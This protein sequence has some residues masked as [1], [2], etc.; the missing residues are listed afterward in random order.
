MGNNK[1][2]NKIVVKNDDFEKSILDF[3][4]NLDINK[5]QRLGVAV[6]GGSD[7]LSL[8]VA[9]NNLKYDVLAILVNHNLRKN[10]LNEIKQTSK[11][12]EKFGIKYVIKQWDGKY[13]K[14][15]E[16]EAR[17]NRYRL[18][19]ETCKENKIKFL[20]IGHHIDDQMETFLLNL[21]RGSGLDGLCAM[22]KIMNANDINI[23][24]PMLNLTKQDCRNYLKNIN[25]DWCE[26]ESN[27][28][29]KYKRN[30]IR[31]LLNQFEDKEILTKRI[32][33]SVD[34]LQEVREFIDDYIETIFNDKNIIFFNDK[35]NQFEINKNE[36]LKLKKYIQKSIIVKCVAVISKIEYKVSLYKTENILN[37]I[38]SNKPFKR[39]IEKCFV[40]SE[41]R[42]ISRNKIIIAYLDNTKNKQ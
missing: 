2:N 33:R 30:K 6:S 13:K 14:N 24:R 26:D 37:D 17:K 28:D 32:V 12:L 42:K 7:S 25:I 39:T 23:V 10:A 15:L 36:F 31:Y 9:L 3:L 27:N 34:S 20:C 11:T 19:I 21:M 38:L 5:N 18:L 22:P 35:K 16:A 1:I 29:I 4:Q 40:E 41:K 8:V